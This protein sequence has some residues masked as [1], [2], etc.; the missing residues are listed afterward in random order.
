VAL[1]AHDELVWPAV[2]AALAGAGV[3]GVLLGPRADGP[4]F[5]FVG[6]RR[7]A[8]LRELVGDPPVGVPEAAWPSGN[9]ARG[10]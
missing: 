10:A 6:S 7:L 4:A 5:R 9:Y 8:R 2:G 3:P 1:G